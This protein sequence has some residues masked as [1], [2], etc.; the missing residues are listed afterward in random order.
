MLGV[1]LVDGELLGVRDTVDVPLLLRLTVRD[2][3]ND[4][5]FVRELV[6]VT[7]DVGELV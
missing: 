6:I 2:G 1:R 3:V 7:D 4:L 5:L